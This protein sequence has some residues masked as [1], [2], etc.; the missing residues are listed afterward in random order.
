MPWL[1]TTV[2]LGVGGSQSGSIL[3][4]M[5]EH[6]P[7]I[8][9][10]RSAAPGLP[11]FSSNCLALLAARSVKVRYCVSNLEGVAATARLFGVGILDGETFGSEIFFVINRGPLNEFSSVGINHQFESIV[12]KFSVIEFG[13][14]KFE[15][16]GIT[17]TTSRFDEHAQGL[18]CQ[19]GVLAIKFFNFGYGSVC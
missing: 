8:T 17:G 10:S 5:P 1:S 16:I 3:Y 12:R 9:R 11:V 6:P 4:S 13:I 2:S 15:A 19:R 14:I 7:E 18:A